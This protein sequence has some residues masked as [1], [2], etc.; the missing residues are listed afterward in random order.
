MNDDTQATPA[1]QPESAQGTS[2][3]TERALVE[4]VLLMLFQPDSKT[5]AGENILFYVLGGAVVAELAMTERAEPREAGV[6]SRP[7]HAIGTAP[8]A[9]ALLTPAWDYIIDKPRKVQ[10]I[11]AAV[12][13]NLR[14][15]VLERLVERGDLIEERYKSLGFIPATR[16]VLGSDRRAELLE[17]VQAVLL[18]GEEPDPRTGALVALLSASGTLPQFHRDIPWSSDVYTRGKQLEK[19]DWGAVAASRAVTRTMI[20]II[21]SSLAVAAATASR[22]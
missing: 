8:P 1:D 6:I 22:N 17:R 7:I 9:D 12:G 19:G 11:L 16:Y 18:R 3:P 2:M 4:D 21:S 10:T 15:P 5:I 14:A 20:A 13:P